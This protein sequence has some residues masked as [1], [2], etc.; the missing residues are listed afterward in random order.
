V[1]VDEMDLASQALDVTP[2]RPEEYERARAVLRGAMAESGTQP[3][4]RRE[5]APMPA[6]AP[7]H[8]R[9]SSRAGNRHRRTLGTRGKVGIGAGLG[10]IAAGVAAALVITSAPSA[11]PT[12]TGLAVKAP[13]AQSNSHPATATAQLMSLSSRVAAESKPTGDATL[14]ERESGVPGTATINVWDLYADDG[15]YFFSQTEAGLPAQVS[16]DNNQGG[17]QF[18]REIAAATY[19][20]KGD[21]DTA[22]LK[23][24]WAPNGTKVPAWL[25]AQV[26]DLSVGGTQLDNYVWEDSEDA[27][28]AGSGNPQVRAGVLRLVSAL[29]DITVDKGT[30]DGQPALTFT[31][32]KAE[33]GTTGVDKKNPKAEVGPANHEAITINASTGIPLEFATGPTGKITVG[34]TYVVT[35]VSLSDIKAGKF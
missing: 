32:G 2:W 6:V 30:V 15:Q 25:S 10:A 7:L 27:L 35:R 8:G 34:L 24:A 18:A 33:V 21:L 13:G 22:L 20:V 3:E 23:M 14:I 5:A 28:I 29:P 11:T 16:K 19:A 17:G 9:G 31:A 1:T 26:K 12:S 4:A